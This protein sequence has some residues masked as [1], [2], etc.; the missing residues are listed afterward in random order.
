MLLGFKGKYK[1]QE[2]EKRAVA[3][4]KRLIEKYKNLY[5]GGENIYT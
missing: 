5:E 2:H 4:R 1:D 3:F